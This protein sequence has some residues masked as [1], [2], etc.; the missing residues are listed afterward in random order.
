MEWPSLFR[1]AWIP[2]LPAGRV[3]DAKAWGGLISI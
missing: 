1:A 3:K 2:G